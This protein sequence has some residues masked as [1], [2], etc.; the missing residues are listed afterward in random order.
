M[1]KRFYLLAVFIIAT[2]VT[3][4]Q[5]RFIYGFL[6]DSITYFPIAEGTV[7]NA[8]TNKEV[9][10]DK[11]GFFRLQVSPNDFIYAVAKSYHYDTL[12]YSFI[13][14]D[15]ITIYLS[16]IGDI[17]PNV[18]VTTRYNKYQLDSIQRRAD[19]EKLRGTNYRTLSTDHPSGFG[20]T[21]NLDPLLN[22]KDRV[23]RNAGKIFSKTEE[24]EYVNY[25]FSPHLV[26][27][28]TG[29]KGDALSTFM[30]RY[31]PDYSWLRKH[32][33]NEDVMLYINDKLK[34][35]KASLH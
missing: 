3:N 15:T 2:A 4:A 11:D 34:K 32:L 16:P 9:Q 21:F 1:R 7:T 14:T 8:S 26:A 30:N 33:T 12:K 22:K 28:Y 23:K 6:R 18:T 20:L 5:A 25:R 31:T 27:Y 35:Y 24:M 19:F 17:L 10:S 13:N 29:L